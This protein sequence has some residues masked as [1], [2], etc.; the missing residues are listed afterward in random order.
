MLRAADLVLN[1]GGVCW[2]D[3]FR[4]CRRR[5]FIDMDPF[6]TQVGKFGAEALQDHHFHFSYGANIGRGECTVPTGGVHWLPTHPPVVTDLWEGAPEPSLDAPLTTIANWS[7][8]GAV[9]YAGERYGQKDEEFLR[10]IDLPRRTAQPLELALSGAAGEVVEQLRARG[11][12]VRNAA[13]VSTEVPAYR[14]YIAGSRGEFSAAKHAYVKT[15][16]GWFSDRSVC[17]L[18]AGRPA[19][20]QDTGWS[21]WLPT[22]EGAV[23]FSTPDEAAGAL[24]RVNQNYAA[25]CGA[26][27]R[28]AEQTFSYRVTLPPLL[29][30]ALGGGG[31]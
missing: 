20:L 14:S 27:R 24:E 7:A 26:A 1:I 23:A 29:D 19:V 4:L 2:L 10:L 15:R 12:S 18:A 6:F 31:L 5:A 17:Y 9:T 22:N 30:Q 25:H 3:E 16:S 8:Y 13:E 21:D 28:I 11:W